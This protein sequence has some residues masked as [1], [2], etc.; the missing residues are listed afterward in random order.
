MYFAA[1]YGIIFGVIGVIVND[2]SAVRANGF[3]QG[4]VGI[5][6]FVVTLQV[7]SS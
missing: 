7:K 3:F 4:Y 1:F 6:W 5:T 2:F